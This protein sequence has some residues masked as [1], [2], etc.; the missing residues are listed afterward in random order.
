M[1]YKILIIGKASQHNLEDT[2]FKNFTYLN[3]DCKILDIVSIRNNLSNFFDHQKIYF[4]CKNLSLRKIISQN[5]HNLIDI[6]FR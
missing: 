3:I 6:V 4:F 5:I 2:Y 1:K